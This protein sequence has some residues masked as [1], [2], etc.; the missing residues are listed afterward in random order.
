MVVQIFFFYL[1]RFEDWIDQNNQKRIQPLLQFLSPALTLTGAELNTETYRMSSSKNAKFGG[2][3]QQMHNLIMY[4]IIL[5]NELRI[6]DFKNWWGCARANARANLFTTFAFQQNIPAILVINQKSSDGSSH[7][8]KHY[9]KEDHPSISVTS[10]CSYAS[11]AK[12]G[13]PT[14][15]ILRS[16]LE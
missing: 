12:N 13:T 8:F 16:R 4:S 14:L 3:I 11:V 10:V 5:F 1:Y 7:L 9:T 2:C 15:T 6:R